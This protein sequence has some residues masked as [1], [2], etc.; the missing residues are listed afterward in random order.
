[1]HHRYN[2]LLRT[3]ILPWSV[4]VSMVGVSFCKSA[5]Q[6]LRD[7]HYKLGVSDF[8]MVVVVFTLHVMGHRQRRSYHR[9]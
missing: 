6:L 5:D 8:D 2:Y 9:C 3:W 1:M 4:A 7:V